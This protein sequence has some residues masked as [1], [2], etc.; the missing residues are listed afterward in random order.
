MSL[1]R[2]IPRVRGSIFRRVVWVV[3][4]A[5]L[6]ALALS[7][8]AT[9]KIVRDDME[10]GLVDG[11]LR[12]G[13]ASRAVVDHAV[14]LGRTQLRAA[15]LAVELGRLNE[16]PDLLSRH[17][18]AVRFSR[19]GED[20]WYAARDAARGARLRRQDAWPPGQL[21]SLDGVTLGM[22]ERVGDVHA[23]AM[24]DVRHALGVPAQW[25]AQLVEGP[26]HAD[27]AVGVVVRRTYPEDG[28]PRVHVTAPSS[29]GPVV[30]LTA[31]LAPAAQRAR[32]LTR[33]TVM[34][35][36]LAVVPLV[37]LA[38][39]LGRMVTRPVRALADAVHAAG[40]GPVRLPPL[41]HDEIGELGQAIQRSSERLH[42]DTKA[43]R[44]AVRFSRR[45]WTHQDPQ[46]VLGSLQRVLSRAWP[47]QDWHVVSKGQ[48]EDGQV[49]EPI[50]FET[51]AMQA[52]LD[53]HARTSAVPGRDSIVDED[54]SASFADVR[55]RVLSGGHVVLVPL[56]T[57][58]EVY[59]V[60]CGTGVEGD[61]RVVRHAEL[62]CRIAVAALRNLELFE[63]AAVS[64][65]MVALARLSAGVVHEMNNPLAFV[66][67]NLCTLE[68]EL[69]GEQRE[70][71]R[72]AREGAERL[73]RIVRDLS[74]LSKGGA[75]VEVQTCALTALVQRAARVARA[76]RPGIQVELVG[77][78]D[79]RA[80]CDPGRVEQ[81]LVNLMVN[82]AD[83]TAPDDAARV[84]V[85][86]GARGTTVSILVVD[87][88]T[89]IP[90]AAVERLF[91]PFHTTKGP[92]GTGLGLYL[93]RS[94]A[95]AHGGDLGLVSTGP[96]GSAFELTLPDALVRAAL[97]DPPLSL[98]P[99]LD[100]RPEVLVVDDEAA[101][102]R[103]LQRWLGRHA[104]VTAVTDPERG[105]ALA[106]EQEFA[107]VLCDVNM[108]G[109]NG[110]EFAAALQAREGASWGRLVFMTGGATDTPPGIPVLRK[111]L[112]PG[113]VKALLGGAAPGSIAGAASV[114]T[115]EVA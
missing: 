94:F 95:Q 18:V 69:K 82:A 56:R 40:D 60:V 37:L 6:A 88:G 46:E 10:A 27:P 111:P 59:G 75:R 45:V 89:G 65:K 101:I 102:V 25:D 1:R 29:S 106:C 8:L 41:Q 3:V 4:G 15:A 14:D 31:P 52:Q 84:T 113:E 19:D 5:G 73:A 68:E 35:S 17:V 53:N 72:D 100:E 77:Q 20:V 55:A 110:M 21:V 97:S 48:I 33:T 91:Q 99:V 16:V 36:L 57:T 98:R 13:E 112:D 54:P 83:A 103:G 104:E 80:Q 38:W 58:S 47:A 44:A 26:N 51:A 92:D 107:V 28:E 87:N 63:S 93:S 67:A 61:E 64:A 105:L 62:L 81:I 114:D 39:L 50:A 115:A 34:W 42:A 70:A 12:Q 11:A 23:E 78:P 32:E 109:M 96:E 30:A 7:T 66:L 74:S 108:P 79:L 43:L 71:V 76:R 85:Q 86:L 2:I 90:E 49:P 22:A 9:V 24:I